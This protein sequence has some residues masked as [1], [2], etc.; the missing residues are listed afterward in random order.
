MRLVCTDI[1]I[2]LAAAF[3]RNRELSREACAVLACLVDRAALPSTQV[4]RTLDLL[5]SVRGVQRCSNM[6]C[7]VFD[8]SQEQH[9][10]SVSIGMG[11]F[12]AWSAMNVWHQEPMGSNVTCRQ[13]STPTSEDLIAA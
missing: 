10:P 3:D 5:A 9:D 6:L 12:V 7:P 1:I 2:P 8:Y 4:D 11:N 13:L